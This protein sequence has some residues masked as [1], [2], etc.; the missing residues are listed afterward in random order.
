[1]LG[2]AC[3]GIVRKV[4]IQLAVVVLKHGLVKDSVPFKP[5]KGGI[6]KRYRFPV[7]VGARKLLIG[8]V[9]VVGNRHAYLAVFSFITVVHRLAYHTRG[10]VQIPLAVYLLNVG[11]PQISPAPAVVVGLEG[12]G[13]ARPIGQVGRAEAMEA[14]RPARAES[15]VITVV[16]DNHGVAHIGEEIA[17]GVGGVVARLPLVYVVQIAVVIA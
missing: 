10:I 7:A 9:Y 4:H 8:A 14:V 6:F 15:V 11:R 17:R 3:F 13:E 12:V 2:R 1:M 5:F 16:P